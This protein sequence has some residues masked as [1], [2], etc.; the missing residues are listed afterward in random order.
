MTSSGLAFQVTDV[1]VGS[2]FVQR[3]AGITRRSMQRLPATCGLS[4]TP[5]RGRWPSINRRR[6]GTG[7]STYRPSTAL[8][9]PFD[10]GYIAVVVEFG[11]AGGGNVITAFHTTGPKR[12][13]ALI[14]P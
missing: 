3:S 9:T 10:R 4:K 11:S 1:R 7:R 5:W 6:M 12:G 13:E 2:S 14:W 8:P